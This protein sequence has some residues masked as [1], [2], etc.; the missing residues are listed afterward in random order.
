MRA[1]LTGRVARPLTRSTPIRMRG[2]F[3]TTQ[4]LPDTRAPVT[5]FVT[6]TRTRVSLQTGFTDTDVSWSVDEACQAWQIREVPNAGSTV[7]EGTLL[8]SGGA[9]AADVQ[10]VTTVAGSSLSVG[11]GSKLLKI[12]A[13]DLSGNWSVA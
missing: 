13:Q 8:N 1:G 12:F 9:V 3:S 7:A 6:E 11:D 10:Q 5:I 4:I 2:G